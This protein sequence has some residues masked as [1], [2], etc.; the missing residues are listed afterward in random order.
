[1]RFRHLFLL[2][3][4]IIVLAALLFT[5]PDGG[6]STGMLMLKMVIPVLA[7]LF[8]HVARKALFDYDEA[9]F[10]SLLRKASE[11]P[12]GAG[13]A[14]VAIAIVIFGLLGLF[15]GNAHAQDVR[16]YIPAQAATYQSTLQAEQR[17]FWSDHPS[18][19]LLAS[20]VE[21]ESCIS[22]KSP[23]CWNPRS[24]LKTSREEGAGF[25]QITRAFRPDGT[26]RFDAL[27]DM[28][29]THPALQ[30]WSWMNVYQ[31]PDLQLRAL[32]LMSKDN[33]A[34]LRVVADFQAKL[35]FSDAAYNG[36]LG[37]VN[38]D[39][40]ACAVKHGCD[41]QK[42]FG[43]VEQSCTK[44]H[45]ALYGNRSACDINRE[46]VTNVMLVRGPKYRGW[47]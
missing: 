11:S 44:S 19:Y 35:A 38:S 39:R 18:P 47:L 4:G 20:L 29:K 8:A 22:L 15:G 45:A 7:I 26:V 2:G 9:D 24:Q 21:Q 17:K 5:D 3:G 34:A 31:R 36:G 37:G 6:V 12:T 16:T 30:D 33:F 28:R 10:Q 46:H 42:W 25:G 14:L 23:R 13:L 27:S 40:R 32:V 1:M 41:P 43:N